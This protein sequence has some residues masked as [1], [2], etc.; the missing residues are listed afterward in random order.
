[1]NIVIEFVRKR[2]I[3]EK[4]KFLKKRSSKIIAVI[5][6]LLILSVSSVAIVGW[7]NLSKI[8]TVNM[9]E[10]DAE[11][12]IDE[13][14]PSSKEANK[15]HIRN[16]ALI[17]VDAKNPDGSQRS[18]AVM[19]ATINN[20]TKKLKLTSI[21]RDT[22][23][24]VPGKGFSRMGH[25]YSYGGHVLTIKTINTNFQLG[26]RDFVKVD[27]EGLKTIVDAVGGVEVNIK[28]YEI[29]SLKGVGIQK[30][31]KHNLNGTQA[32][33][34]SR[35]RKAGAGDYERTERQRVV[36]MKIFE[37]LKA[38]GP[39]AFPGIVSNLLPHVETSLTHGEI[40]KLGMDVLSSGTSSLEQARIPYD[41]LKKEE[42]I[43][44][45]FYITYDEEQTLER[46]HKF[47]WE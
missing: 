22:Y 45:A 44:G 21:M 19:V 1:L 27:F 32:L 42:Y 6:G 29:Q 46:L 31:G 12:G 30:S 25:T 11:L 28:E 33:A 14:Q 37:K 2:R 35:I 41:N 17:G 20:E 9:R 26:V 43:N 34:Y 8:K 36:M 5:L 23:V 39:T 10:T 4:M 3:G 24:E 47:I 7:Y 38:K 13:G 40:L 15:A 18:D 16:I